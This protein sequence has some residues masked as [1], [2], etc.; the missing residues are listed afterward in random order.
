MFKIN[1]NGEV[2]TKSDIKMRH[3]F[4]VVNSSIK[5]HIVLLKLLSI[6]LI[7]VIHQIID[8]KMFCHAAMTLPLNVRV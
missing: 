6:K 5:C 8:L 4:Y 1:V 2:G 7:I 3:A